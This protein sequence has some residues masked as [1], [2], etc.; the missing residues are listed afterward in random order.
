[1]EKKCETEGRGENALNASY[2][3]DMPMKLSYRRLC[4]EVPDVAD[5]AALC[6]CDV[7]TRRVVSHDV[8]FTGTSGE[9]CG[10]VRGDLESIYSYTRELSL[11]YYMS[12][13]RT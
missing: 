6:T 4:I 3:F 5:S 7:P 11:L 9:D 12:R 1:M 10:W 2:S 13:K 8:G